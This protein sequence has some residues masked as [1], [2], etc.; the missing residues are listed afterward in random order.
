MDWIVLLPPVVAIGLAMWTRQIYLS[1]FAGLWLGTTILAGGNP[2]L[3]LRELADQIVTVFTTE[4]N[5][6]ILVF[7]LL[8]GGLVALVQASGGV[9]GFIKWARARG[10]GE[11]RRG[12]ELLAWGIGVVLFV[13]SNIS[14]LTVGAVSRPLFDRLNLPRE[15]LA[16]YCDATCAPVC[17]SIP[18]NGWGAFVLGLVGAQELSQNA[19]AV[20]AEAVLFNFFA[21][22]A[23][24]FSLVLALTGWGFGAMRRAEKRAADTGQ[25]LRPDAQPMIEDDV[26]RIEPPDHVTP[27][28]RNLLLPV[29]VMVAMIFVGLYV[30][31]GGNLMEGSGSTAVLWAVGTALGAA[32]LL[33]AIPRPLREGR[34]T[35]TLGTSMDWVVKGASGLVPVTLLLVL[36]FALGQVSQALE[37]GDYVVQLVGEQGPAWWMPVLV[38]AVTSFVAFTLGSSWTAF[39]ILI[40]VVMPLA[41]EVALP[42]SLML[43]AVLSGG[44]F[45]DHTSPLS[46]TSIISSMAAASDHVD[47][48]NTQM[49][50]ALVQAGMAAVAFVV[51]GLL[52]G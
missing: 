3:G 19:V 29:A 44:I 20:L 4:S 26:A 43:G 14:S 50:Y 22:F 12:A 21:L 47:H 32:L 13:E 1:L 41:V 49:P 38:F 6:R 52:A 28:A 25:V 31:G 51:A 40:P 34:A 11:S 15:K 37:M 30:T 42:S 9:Q 5:A 18:L 24:G 27:Q 35:L 17:M 39:A 46:D 2:V 10:W 33:Y 23:I 48:V 8:V 7:C 36:A 16:Y 45:G